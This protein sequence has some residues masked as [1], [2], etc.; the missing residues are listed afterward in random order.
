MLRGNC[1]LQCLFWIC[2]GLKIL[3]IYN[4]PTFILPQKKRKDEKKKIIPLKKKFFRAS[5]KK[6]FIIR[7]SFGLSGCVF[8][9]IIL[10]LPLAIFFFA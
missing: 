6:K 2:K 8:F 10:G 3:E 7:L 1:N 5:V 9:K 4:N